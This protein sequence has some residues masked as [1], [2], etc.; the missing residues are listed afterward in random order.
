MVRTCEV[1]PS[2]MPGRRAGSRVCRWF[3][4]A[5]PGG[6]CISI[7]IRMMQQF[8]VLRF[9]HTCGLL[10]ENVWPETVCL[11]NAAGCS[12]CLSPG[13]EG[14]FC[15]FQALQPSRRFMQF[16]AEPHR[17]ISASRSPAVTSIPPA[18][19]SSMPRRT[20]STSSM[21]P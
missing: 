2:C 19:L 21:Y 10:N 8:R 20:N 4:E 16:Q 3:Q 14:A 7:V 1:S 12:I 13:F 11:P 9:F 18:S 15:N 17:L 6:A 5:R